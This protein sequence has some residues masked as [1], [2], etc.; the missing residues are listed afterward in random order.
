MDRLTAMLLKIF[1]FCLAKTPD[2]LLSAIAMT[3]GHALATIP[4]SRKRVLF[5]NLK[6]AFPEWS[7][8]R[9]RRVALASAAG[10]VEMGFFSLAYPCMS[11]RRI[12][13]SLSFSSDAAVKMRE[14]QRSGE[15][16]VVFIPHVALFETLGASPLFAPIGDK[17]LGGI[18]RPHRNPAI[19]KWVL[20]ARERSGNRMFARDKALVSSKSHLL[21]NNWLAV[22]YDQNAGINGTLITFLDRLASATPLP[23]LL[24]KGTKARAVFALPQRKSFFRATLFLQEMKSKD[25][26]GLIAESH[27]LLERYL[28]SSDKACAEWLWAHGRWKTQN[29]APNRFRLVA[30][31]RN[32]PTPTKFPRKTKFWIRMPNWLGDV[33]MALPLLQALR[34][35]RPDAE[36]TL[37]CRAQF[38]PLL[39]QMGVADSIKVLPEKGSFDYYLQFLT[40]RNE[41][42][43]LHL[44]LTNSLRGDLEALLIGAPQRFGLRLPGRSRR[45]LTDAHRP[46][47]DTIARLK[48]LHQTR[49]WEGMMQC[50]GLEVELPQAPFALKGASRIPNKIGLIPGASNNPSKRWPPDNWAKL[51]QR[52]FKLRPEASIHLYGTQADREA[53]DAIAGKLP[54]GKTRNQAGSTDL[55]QLAEE[56]AS[57]SLVIGNDTGGMHLANAVGTPVAVLCGP[58]NPLVTGPFFDAPKVCLQPE[59][60]PPEGGHSIDLLS[61]DQVISALRKKPFSMLK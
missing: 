61:V 13:R 11:D 51:C 42:P 39:E 2:N 9:I 8:K 30:K 10:M 14:L 52:I 22:L 53:T 4:N 56:L 34:I 1:G 58:T 31:R 33:V 41:L 27:E 40:W 26:N 44:L 37:L 12:R 59:D 54:K 45:L 35:G 38:R 32:L 60:C 6:R 47:P 3:I 23:G 25:P 5:S 16:V 55:N 36:L 28:R 24:A 15:P 20:E 21:D 7:E 46:A 43:D 18:Y 19:E 29:R 48:H 17:K 49:L 50:F 57:C